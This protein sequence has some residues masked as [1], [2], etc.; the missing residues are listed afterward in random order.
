MFVLT[1]WL[2]ITW[3]AAKAEIPVLT[4]LAAA[5]A[6]EIVSATVSDVSCLASWIEP[7]VTLTVYSTD[8]SVATA[9]VVSFVPSSS[10]I[11]SLSVAVPALT[12]VILPYLSTVKIFS[13]DDSYFT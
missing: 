1:S 7:P 12:P 4:S 11:V 10:I 13:S 9:L 3:Y 8:G 2:A 5:P 6:E